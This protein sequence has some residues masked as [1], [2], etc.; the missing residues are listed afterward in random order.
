VHRNKFLFNK[1]NRRNNFPN[2]FCQ[3]TL[4]VSGCFSAHHQEFSIAHSALVYVQWK[5]LMMGRETARNMLS[6][7]T[8]Q[9]WEISASAGFI[10]KKFT[11]SSVTICKQLTNHRAIPI[12]GSHSYIDASETV[13]SHTAFNTSSAGR[14]IKL[15]NR[16][17]KA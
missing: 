1:T 16:E 9:I 3:E 4:Y 11:S 17:T 12:T 8:K 15:R 2:L 10:K 5:L 7:L 13:T 14:I 6:F